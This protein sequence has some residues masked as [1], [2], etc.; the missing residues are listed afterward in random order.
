MFSRNKLR[1]VVRD[2]C[3]K[4][5]IEGFHSNH[6]L[7]TTTCLLALGKGV[8]EKVIMDRARHWDV[9]SPLHAYRRK[10]GKERQVVSYVIQSCKS[11]LLRGSPPENVITKVHE[12]KITFNVCTVAVRVTSEISTIF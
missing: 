7:R 6:S 8:S 2:L 11:S 3:S 4:A 1:N 10:S 9:K 5:N 12:G